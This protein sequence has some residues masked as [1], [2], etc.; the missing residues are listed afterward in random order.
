MRALRGAILSARYGYTPLHPTIPFANAL[1]WLL[2]AIPAA[3]RRAT[4]GRLRGIRP[5]RPHGRLLEIGCGDGDYLLPM[6]E[7]GW[8]IHGIE[9]DLLG[10]ERAARATGARIWPGA[11]SAVGS[12]MTPRTTKPAGR[13]SREFGCTRSRVGRCA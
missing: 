10:A 12:A 2:S 9:P 1:G 6:R 11:G 4:L 5:Y 7:L 13:G 3:H 8:E